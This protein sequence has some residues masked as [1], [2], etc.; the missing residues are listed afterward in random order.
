MFYNTKLKENIKSTEN[1]E[2]SS[3]VIVAK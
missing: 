3:H 1:V 2:N